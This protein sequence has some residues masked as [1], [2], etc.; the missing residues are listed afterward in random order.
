MSKL[1]DIST[2]TTK[3]EP[4]LTLI[5]DFA[6]VIKPIFYNSNVYNSFNPVIKQVFNNN[7]L[8]GDIAKCDFM[9]YMFPIDNTIKFTD[10]TGV[11]I[12]YTPYYI[13]FTAGCP[14]KV[15]TTVHTFS[16]IIECVSATNIPLLIIIP[17]DYT[18]TGDNNTNIDLLIKYSQSTQSSIAESPSNNIY[19]NNIIPSDKF[20]YFKKLVSTSIGNCNIIT[21]GTSLKTSYSQDS[22]KTS[23]TSPTK[24][25]S[26]N[27]VEMKVTTLIYPTGIVYSASDM[28]NVTIY[29][30]DN[31]TFNSPSIAENDIY[32]DC[33]VVTD[34]TSPTTVTALPT[35]TKTAKNS[36]AFIIW[37]IVIFISSFFIYKWIFMSTNTT[38]ISKPSHK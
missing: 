4:K 33:S 20:I 22:T 30:S 34:S 14:I 26:T 23:S 5:Y 31:T 11:I 19:I 1:I 8:N 18:S 13:H 7:N 24:T 25:F 6:T 36:A 17:V 32:I 12:N 37:L 3:T 16:L 29:K 10:N 35:K 2:I 15:T 9:S 28:A 21:F 27:D 38:T